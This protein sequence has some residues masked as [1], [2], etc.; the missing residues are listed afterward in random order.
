MTDA[1]V[2]CE[3]EANSLDDWYCN[4]SMTPDG[5]IAIIEVVCPWCIKDLHKIKFRGLEQYNLDK[6][7]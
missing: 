2:F 6:K 5:K 1:C 7:P 3:T 4:F